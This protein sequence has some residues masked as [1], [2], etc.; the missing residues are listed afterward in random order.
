MLK[1]MLKKHCCGCNACVQICPVN[2][3]TPQKDREGF[4]Y[5]DIDED[6][7]INCN[8]CE[9]VCPMFDTLKSD[10]SFKETYITY[11]NNDKIRLQSSSG[12]VF[13]AVSDEILCSGGVVYGAAFDEEF[14]VRHIR[15]DSIEDMYMLRGSKY[16]QSDIGDT[17][18][19]VKADLNNKKTVLYTGTAC[20]IAG[21]KKFLNKDYDSLY[22]IDVLCHG[23]PSPEIWRKYLNELSAAY[24]SKV[25]GVNFRKKDSGWKKY[26]VEIE[27]ENGKKYSC[28]HSNNP[29]MKIFLSD[30]C[31]RPS[32]H[33]CKYK[34]LDRPSDITIGDCW[35]VEKIRP[36]MDD[37]K[38]TSVVIVHTNKGKEIFERISK[39]LKYE[40]VDVDE[41]LPESA[42][43]RK[44]VAPHVKRDKFFKDFNNDKNFTSLLKN[45]ETPKIKRIFRK[46]KRIVKKI[47]GR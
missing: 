44:S 36:D 24:K 2:C 11:L 16:L 28:V 38:G 3:I 15:V 30:I 14:M 46:M 37:D 26:S 27:F 23:V 4:F 45:I 6:K 41:I 42:D 22:T 19:Q 33:E 31:L 39:T 43:S 5:P 8:Q 25:V 47:S 32:C 13:S 20:Q 34:Q 17:F 1:L 21:L 40:S 12:G 9:K 10:N 29:F 18:V 7:C 35:G